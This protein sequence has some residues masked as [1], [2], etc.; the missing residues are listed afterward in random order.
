MN[1]VVAFRIFLK[2]MSFFVMTTIL[3]L[4]CY[5]L[6]EGVFDWKEALTWGTLA[7]LAYIIMEWKGNSKIKLFAL[8][9]L[10]VFSYLQFVNINI[11]IKY[12]YECNTEWLFDST[13]WIYILCGISTTY[14]LY[15]QWIILLLSSAG[16]MYTYIYVVISCFLL[17]SM[18]ILMFVPRYYYDYLAILLLF[19]VP[20]IH[21]L[22]LLICAI[23][24]LVK[25]IRHKMMHDDR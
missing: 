8:S 21:Y 20:I 3:C 23:I 5:M 15:Q 12:V 10:F 11:T 22:I 24:M 16:K 19:H 13:R 17:M 9:V 1:K 14:A 25:N 4:N 2:L 7:G 6:F 18:P